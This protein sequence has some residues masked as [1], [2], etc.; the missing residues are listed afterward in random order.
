MAGA[1]A[2]FYFLSDPIRLP[3]Y[4]PTMQLEYSIAV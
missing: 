4:V 1:D 3:D 2:A